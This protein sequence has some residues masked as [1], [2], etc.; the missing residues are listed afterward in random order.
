MPKT[1]ADL[2]LDG[3]LVE[4]W[5]KMGA[6]WVCCFFI[7]L[8]CKDSFVN[9]ILSEALLNL[10]RKNNDSTL[11]FLDFSSVSYKNGF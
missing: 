11:E 6:H 4:E 10:C 2:L 3:I 7:L 8:W 1:S 9:D 5:S